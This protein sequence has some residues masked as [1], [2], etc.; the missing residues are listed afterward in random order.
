MILWMSSTA[1]GSTPANGSSSRM[2]AGRVPSARAI[3]SAPPLAARQRD[4]GVLAQVRDVQVLQQ[5]VE[6]RLDLAGPEA[7]QLEHRPHVLLHGE[8]AEHRVLLRQVGD[9]QARA[10]VDRQ[11]GEL[12]AVEVDRAR[13]HRHQ[14]HDHVEAGRL[15]GAVGA[16][17]ADHLAARDLERHVLHHR[18]GLVALAQALRCSAGS[19]HFLASSAALGWIVARTRPCGAPLPALTE[20]KSVRW[21]TKM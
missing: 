7:L 19:F 1:I 14:A 16:E 5:L 18:A 2:K 10:A 4:R 8:A 12:V 17:Q 9:P 3:S 13:V 6:P 20:K 15:A 21:S 11:V